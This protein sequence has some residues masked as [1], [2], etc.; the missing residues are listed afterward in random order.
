MIQQFP[1]KCLGFVALLLAILGSSCR[2]PIV[3]QPPA[4]LH[5]V[6]KCKVNEVDWRS[7]TPVSVAYYLNNTL[8]IRGQDSLNRI[9]DLRM[10][11]PAGLQTGEYLLSPNTA[12]AGFVA[13]YV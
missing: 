13:T 6:L 2:E 11:F 1:F 10:G 12:G 8:I 3:S 5:H 4:Q 7:T 9:I